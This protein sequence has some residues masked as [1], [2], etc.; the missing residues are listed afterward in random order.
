MRGQGGGG[1]VGQLGRHGAWGLGMR[2]GVCAQG[3]VGLVEI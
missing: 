3:K 1:L 2:A